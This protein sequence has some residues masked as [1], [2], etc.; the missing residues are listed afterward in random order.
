MKPMKPYEEKA[1][2][3]VEAGRVKILWQNPD[4]TAAHGV[5][6]GDTDTYQSSFSPEGYVCTC[7]AGGA[8]KHCSHSLAVELMVAWASLVV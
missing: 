2:R 8:H 5:V 4:G 6:D 1:I 7:P 3:L